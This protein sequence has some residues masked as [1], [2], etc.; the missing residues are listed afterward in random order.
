M[1]LGNYLF[2]LNETLI[3][4]YFSILKNNSESNNIAPITPNMNITY[5]KDSS[6]NILLE[7]IVF[8]S[9]TVKKFV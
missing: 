5:L 7:N 9:E 3:N 1:V 8:N 2:S 6:L 4:K